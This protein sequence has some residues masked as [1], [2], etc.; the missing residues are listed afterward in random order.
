MFF[1]GVRAL[2]GCHELEALSLRRCLNIT[3]AGIITLAQGCPSVKSLEFAPPIRAHFPSKQT[4]HCY[5]VLPHAQGTLP[6]SLGMRPGG[7]RCIRG[8][9]LAHGPASLSGAV[10]L[11]CRRSFLALS[12][13][14]IPTKTGSD[15][16]TD[17]RPLTGRARS[18]L[19]SA[20]TPGI[21]SGS[22]SAL[23]L[24]L[25][26]LTVVSV[27]HTRRF[28]AV[29]ESMTRP[30]WPSLLH[31]PPISDAT[32]CARSTFL[33]A[34]ESL[35]ACWIRLPVIVQSHTQSHVSHCFGDPFVL[36]GAIALPQRHSFRILSSS[37]TVH[38]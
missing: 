5:L 25:T 1:T 16:D 34:R 12:N 32:G 31:F 6:Q 22:Y 27:Q 19:Q 24:L 21:A 23:F 9:R 17:H 3:D 26:S 36:M 4:I 15:R 11:H 18:P 7:R 8:Y 29:T 10:P 14:C 13:P 35:L 38:R 28:V 2:P 20:H 37:M 30:Y 33:T